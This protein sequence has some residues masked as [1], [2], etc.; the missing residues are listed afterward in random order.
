MLAQ[1]FQLLLDFEGDVETSFCR[2]FIA[3]YDQFGEIQRVPL[4]PGGETIPLTRDNRHGKLR[5]S[6]ERA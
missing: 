4:K 1:S 2:D 6:D 5:I 3:T